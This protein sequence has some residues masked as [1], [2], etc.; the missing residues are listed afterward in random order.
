MRRLFVD[1]AEWRLRLAAIALMVSVLGFVSSDTPIDDALIYARYIQNALRGLGLVFNAGEHIN[2]LSSPLYSY[3]VLGLATILHGHVL[4]ASAAISAVFMFLACVVAE[5]LVPFAGFV[6]AGTGYFYSLVGMETSLFLFLLLLTVALAEAE[7][8]AW[9]PTAGILLVLTRFEG[10]AL[11][12]P[13]AF[14]LARKRRWPP[15]ITFL[16][17]LLIAAFYLGLNHHWYGSF[18]PASA[19]AKIGQGRSEL[20]GRWPTSFFHTAYQLKPEFLPTVYVVVLVAILAVPGFLKM[21]RATWSRIALPFL[22]I[23]LAFYILFNIPGYKWYYAPFIC[24]AM[25]YACAAIP[26]NGRLRWLTVP[27]ILLAAATSTW[28]FIKISRPAPDT[29]YVAVSHWFIANTPPGTRVEAGEIGTLGFDCE[30]CYLMD[31]LGLT[32][33][34]NA[35]HVAHKDIRSWL[36]EDNPEYIVVHRSPWQFEDVAKQSPNYAPLA[37]DFGPVVYVLK[38]KS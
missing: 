35:D 30:Q 18:F 22:G 25:V 19:N 7:L 31:S 36:A 11:L 2:A 1:N 32:L 17:A 20:W 4:G 10:A 16:P 37:V 28:R 15:A 33:P 26:K 6:I 3:L 23:L 29:G 38:R 14:V 24:F 27:I 9:L 21:K 5:S 34:K 13:L 12:L 8:Y